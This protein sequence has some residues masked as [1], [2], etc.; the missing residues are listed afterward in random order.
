DTAGSRAIGLIGA[1]RYLT[2]MGMQDLLL[3]VL[4]S[5]MS[6]EWTIGD[7]KLV[8]LWPHPLP[9]DSV[10]Y[11]RLG[12]YHYAIEMIGLK[13]PSARADIRCLAFGVSLRPTGTRAYADYIASVMAAWGWDLRSS[14]GEALLFEEQGGFISMLVADTP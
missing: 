6:P 13:Q 7:A 14:D 8:C 9:E 1:T 2:D 5:M 4:Y 11:V 12:A 10:E 3:R